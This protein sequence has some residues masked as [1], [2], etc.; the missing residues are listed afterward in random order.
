MTTPHLTEEQVQRYALMD[1]EADPLVKKHLHAC[2]QCKE[3]VETY[4][5]LFEGLQRQAQPAFDFDLAAL[6][7][8]EL[9]SPVTQPRPKS[10]YE[11]LNFLTTAA[12]AVII[13]A[14]YFFRKFVFVL[15]ESIAP[16]FT[17]LAVSAFV[18]LSG[19]LIADMYKN[20]KK[21][22]HTLDLYKG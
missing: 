8:A 16:I 9:P 12:V 14:L 17:Y 7:I 19:L 5:F 20:Y 2:K 21:K 3:S 22:I 1:S 13:Y 11:L 18:T 15:F 10:K 4:R 6:V